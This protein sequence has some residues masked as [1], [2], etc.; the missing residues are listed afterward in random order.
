MYNYNSTL[1]M[2][3]QAP[4][5]FLSNN[6]YSPGTIRSALDYQYNTVQRD[7]NETKGRSGIRLVKIL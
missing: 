7:T 5:L 6:T 4:S 3:S 1:E 2:L